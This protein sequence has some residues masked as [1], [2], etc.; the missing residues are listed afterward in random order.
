MLDPRSICL[1]TQPAI[2]GIGGAYGP[3]K[4]LAGW[5]TFQIGK[6]IVPH[7][8]VAVMDVATAWYLAE[9]SLPNQ[10][11]SALTSDRKVALTRP[12]TM[13]LAIE[14]LRDRVKLDRICE[15]GRRPL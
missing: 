4:M 11:V 9:S 14:I 10:P 12:K 5:R 13:E 15:V 6:C 2:I 1:P 3:G 7:I 8:G